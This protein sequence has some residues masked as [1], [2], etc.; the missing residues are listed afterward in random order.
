MLAITDRAHERGA[1]MGLLLQDLLELTHTLTRLQAVPAL[2]DGTELPEAERI[3]RRGAGGP[4][5]H[6]GARAAA[7]RCC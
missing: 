1:D 3:A 5:V 4:A 2:R 7:G 6:A